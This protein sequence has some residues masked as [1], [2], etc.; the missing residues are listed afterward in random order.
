M[1]DVSCT[2]I[3]AQEETQE[4]QVSTI[5]YSPYFCGLLF[6]SSMMVGVMLFRTFTDSFEKR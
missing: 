2:P 1:P 3:L 6:I 4:M 5:D